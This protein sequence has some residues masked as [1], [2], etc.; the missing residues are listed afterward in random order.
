MSPDVPFIGL[1][2]GRAALV[3]RPLDGGEATEVEADR[4]FPA[5]SLIKLPILAAALDAGLPLGE[6]LPAGPPVPGSGVLAHLADIGDM[7]VR[8]L[9]TL[10]I[11]VSD[12]TATNIIIDRIGMEEVNAWCER[13]GLTATVLARRMMDA[14]ARERGLENLTSAADVASVLSWLADRPFAVTAL[15]AQQLNDRLPRHL[16]AGFR[17]AHKT[18]E[19]RGVRHDAGIIYPPSGAPVVVAVLTEG[20]AD[21]AGL[22]AECGRSVFARL[23]A[24]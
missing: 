3:V 24:S 15:E 2:T 16:P 10:M 14:R 9:L 18:G 1:G 13:R 21:G 4:R 8:D 11:A 20:C 19:L 23:A 22:I 12:N 7:S 17:L 6:R 5:A